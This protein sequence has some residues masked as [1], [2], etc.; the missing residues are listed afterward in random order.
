[1]IRIPPINLNTSASVIQPL[2][3]DAFERKQIHV[4]MKRDD[5]IHPFIS[6]NKWRKLKHVLSEARSEDKT[7][8]AT[9]GGAFS[10]HLLAV[11]C[12]GAM[13]G[14]KT[15]GFVRGEEIE[16]KNPVLKMCHLFGM[17]LI[18]ISR[19]DYRDKEAIYKRYLAEEDNVYYIP[20]GGSCAEAL[21][22]VG[23]VI[24][25]LPEVYDQ[26][27]VPT[28]T[29][30]T[31]AGLA[32]AVRDKLLPTEVHGITVIKGGEYLHREI[33][34]WTGMV[35]YHLH[36]NFH[37]GGYAKT[38]NELIVFARN[39]IRNTGIMIEPIYTGKMLMALV[40]L[41]EENHF[42]PK[43]RILCIH[44]GGVWGGNGLLF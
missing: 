11:A 25:E 28:G 14:F 20:E 38:D 10:N 19:G 44:T 29:G 40:Q 23:E 26:I 18:F 15:V 42:K 22:G 34:A 33:E 37:R 1:M 6:G 16:V 13:F 3:L 7:T 43:S 36:T 31:L 41:A 2:L 21:P 39:F 5:L 24:E 27:F 30:G 4:F 9:F 32:L 17:R 8:L 12:S 35:P